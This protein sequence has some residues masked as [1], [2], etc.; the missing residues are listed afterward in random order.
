MAQARFWTTRAL[1]LSVF[2][3]F[4][5]VAIGAQAQTATPAGQAKADEKPASPEIKDL[6]AK[7]AEQGLAA[8]SSPKMKEFIDAV[9][10]GGRPALDFRTNVLRTSKS[11]TERFMAAA[12][13]E[14]VGDPA[15]VDAL[16]FAL[17]GD[18]DDMVRR[19]ASH[20]IALIGTDAHDSA[21][22]G[23]RWRASALRPGP[24]PPRPAGSSS[25]HPSKP[26]L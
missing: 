9:K 21:A 11:A 26:L 5:M 7:L 14:G 18:G 8:F 20:A 19:M 10:A 6:F 24:C 4:L 13:L 23:G 3:L 2:V 1:F 16:A 12:V 22:E 25:R 15:A 17:K